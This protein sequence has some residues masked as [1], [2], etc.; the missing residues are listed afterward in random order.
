MFHKN[1]SIIYSIIIAFFGLVA[2]IFILQNIKKLATY[3]FIIAIDGKEVIENS[4]IL[5]VLQDLPLHWIKLP[6]SFLTKAE[7]DFF[8]RAL[9]DTLV[10][11][12]ANKNIRLIAYD[13]EK[14][15][16]ETY[17]KQ[18]QIYCVQGAFYGEEKK[19]LE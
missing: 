11:F 3:G 17:I 8:S 13:V 6:V 5:G 4:S 1:L 19:A 14:E 2:S 16:E 7:N 15:E 18:L 10:L 9:V 12:A